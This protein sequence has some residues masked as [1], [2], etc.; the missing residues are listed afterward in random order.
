MGKHRLGV[1]KWTAYEDDIRVPLIVR[2]PDVPAD[3]TLEQMVLNN[4]LAPTFID[5]AGGESPAFVDGRSLE[6]L[7]DDGLPSTSS[8]SEG[9]RKG[10][11]VKSAPELIGEAESPPT[12]DDNSPSGSLTG[13]LV[14][15]GDLGRP[16]LKAIRTEDYLY[17]EYASGERELYDIRSGPYQLDNTCTLPR[18]RLSYRASKPG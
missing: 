7:L 10:F 17:V 3:K 2:G 12:N 18:P 9:W 6:P 15:D 5:L 11:L 8:A 16:N 14:P 1:G 4:D 13:D